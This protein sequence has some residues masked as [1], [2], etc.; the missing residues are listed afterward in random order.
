MVEFQ[1]TGSQFARRLKKIQNKIDKPLLSLQGKKSET[2]ELGPNSALFIYLLNYE[3]PETLL[4]ITKTKCYA[5]TTP[6]KKEILNTLKNEDL[7]IFERFKDGSKDDEIIRKLTE[8]TKEVLICDKNN[9]IGNFCLRFIKAFQINDFEIGSLLI[10]KENEEINNVRGAAEFATYLMEKAINM[11]KKEES[12]IEVKLEKFLDAPD[13]A[14]DL[15]LSQLEFVNNPYIIREREYTIINISVRYQS[16]CAEIQRILIHDE[17]YIQVYESRNQIIQT[18]NFEHLKS[19]GLLQREGLR[20]HETGTFVF[21]SAYENATLIDIVAFENGEFSILTDDVKQGDSSGTFAITD[22]II[23]REKTNIEKKRLSRQK[24]LEKEIEINEHQKELMY[25]LN[26]EMIKY[27]SDL[28]KIEPTEKK[29]KK[30]I[31]YEKENHLIRKPRIVIDRRNFGLLIPVKGYMV[32]FHIEFIKNCSSN[33]NDLRINFKEG[34]T[35][36]S[37]TYRTKH[38]NMLLSE[39]NE[40]KKEYFEKKEIGNVSVQGNLIELKGRR[41]ILGD[42][43]LKTE[44]RTQKKNKQNNLEL[45]ENGFK[46][47]DIVILFNNIGHL[48]YQ[49]GDIFLLHFKLR[50]PIIFNGK[51]CYH[52]QFY[53]EVVEN[54]SIDV[55]RY[56]NSDKERLEEEQER[57]RAKSIKQEYDNFIKNV[58]NNTNLR[59]DRVSKEIYFEGVPF[60]Q[61]VQIRPSSDCLVHL[62]EPPFLIVDFEKMEVANFE[63][64]N[65]VSRSFDLTFIFKDKTFLSIS[66]ID[67]R[68]MDYLREFIDSRNI[69]FIQTAQNINWTNLLKTVSDDP[70]CFYTDGGWSSLQPIRDDQELE[71]SSASTLSEP[72][73]ISDSNLTNTDE[74]EVTEEEYN[75]LDD[76]SDEIIDLNNIDSDDYESEEDVPRKKKQRY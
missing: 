36:K 33:G 57:I 59:I 18:K 44:N 75:N 27:H 52:V 53:K 60:R 7:V 15:R 31:A 22:F 61:N 5:V 34:E 26:D 43:K 65:F 19:I 42:V 17:D 6:K 10:E 54:M 51:K 32:P 3:F 74:D 2:E 47:G 68:S 11:I 28:E 72:S 56:A 55:S 4:L 50:V 12:S 62:I 9:L 64:V 48:F 14:F 30:I 40:S 1:L 24:A 23:P 69:C 63:R 46:F 35:V 38:A 16:Y 71:E 41:Y 29:I 13:R 20:K 76:D 67:S 73:S 70:I 58:E 45:H 49:Q 39:I 25:K 66:S 8:I 21:K 37:I